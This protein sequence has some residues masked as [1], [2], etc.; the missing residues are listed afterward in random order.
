VIEEAALFDTLYY[1][2]SAY[3]G[4][5]T[6]DSVLD[7]L[8]QTLLAPS[9]LTT[10]VLDDN[11]IRLNW[12]DNSSGES[13]FSIDRKVGDDNWDIAYAEVDSNSTTFVDDIEL[14]CATLYYRLRA[15][16][17]TLF[18]AYSAIDTININLQIIGEAS[19]P[20]NALKVFV[21]DWNAFVSDEYYGLAVI[22]CF[23]PNVPEVLGYI[24]L[25]DRTLSSYVIGNIAYVATHST[26]SNPG[27]ISKLD[28]TDIAEPILIGYADTQGI[29]KDIFVNGDYAY[30]AEGDAGLSI[31]YIAGSVLHQVSNYDLDDARD[32]FVS[33]N[34]AY[35]AEGL[36]GLKIFDISDH[37]NPILVGEEATS[38]SMIDLH[39]V[40]NYAYVADGENGMKIIDV[41]DPT[42]PMLES[43][44]ITN[45]FVYGV[46][47]EPDYAYFV[48][49][50]FG[51]FAIDVSDYNHP[52]I[53]G[54]IEMDSEPKS[55]CV[56]GS[57]AYVTDN[58]GLKIIKIKP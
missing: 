11:K 18:S 7:S 29:P 19:T 10:T 28:I 38:G 46:W 40:G 35:V 4:S 12:T 55:I 39:V 26:P 9:N 44:V 17:D 37:A 42:N 23:Q 27:R 30:V 24:E 3:F 32:V 16:Q 6:S 22:D 41:S 54:T 49:K 8:F 2:V 53:L 33:G 51:F 34:Y 56:S 47:A 20:G 1:R 5:Q 52:S 31:I 13:G 57:Y 50:E 15:Y 45:G 25:A 43:R 48:D 36:E 58:I 14:Q 21:A